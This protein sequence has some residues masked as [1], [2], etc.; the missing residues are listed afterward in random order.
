MN[1]KPLLTAIGSA[2]FL[3]EVLNALHVL[4]GAIMLATLVAF[5]MRR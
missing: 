1:L 2:I 4:G 3:G 5:H